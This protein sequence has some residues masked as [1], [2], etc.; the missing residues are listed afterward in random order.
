MTKAWKPGAMDGNLSP[1]TPI[2]MSALQLLHHTRPYLGS[3]GLF[4]GNLQHGGWKER[5]WETWSPLHL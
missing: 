4:Y 3:R 2:V 5:G 1:C